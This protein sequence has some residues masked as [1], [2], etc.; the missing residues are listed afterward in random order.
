MV[1]YA[2]GSI[3]S[4]RRSLTASDY[5]VGLAGSTDCPRV[6][7]KESCPKSMC[8]S[9]SGQFHMYFQRP[10]LQ[11][12]KVPCPRRESY[13]DMGSRGEEGCSPHALILKILSRP[14]R[15]TPMKLSVPP[16]L[17]RWTW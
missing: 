17:T 2:Y 16:L 14:A 7:I 5:I 9:R 11:V 6:P 3:S 13:D 12:E 15:Y 4:A 8:R 1:M 10:Y